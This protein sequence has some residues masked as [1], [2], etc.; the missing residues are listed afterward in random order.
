MHIYN[1]F[2]FSH[3]NLRSPAKPFNSQHTNDQNTV[4]FTDTEPKF[5]VAL[6]DL[7]TM[8]TLSVTSDNILN[9]TRLHIDQNIAIIS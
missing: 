2:I 4:S 3:S 7:L 8:N 9:Y 5:I 6:T 1:R